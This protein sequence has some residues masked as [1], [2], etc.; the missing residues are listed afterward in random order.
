MLSRYAFNWSPHRDVRGFY[1]LIWFCVKI[2]LEVGEYAGDQGFQLPNPVSIHREYLRLW[3]RVE[4]CMQHFTKMKLL[5]IGCYG[6]TMPNTIQPEE[7][8]DGQWQ[9]RH[10]IRNRNSNGNLYIR[11]LYFNDGV[12][13][14]NYNWLNN[15]WNGNNPAALL[16]TY[17]ISL[18]YWESFVFATGHASHRASCRSHLSLVIGQYISYR[19]KIWFPRVSSEIFLM[20]LL[21]L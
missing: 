10:S 16:A 11:Y 19:P 1:F 7:L 18:P 17:F 21:F 8:F 13:N 20:Y 6:I 12:W 3:F 4:W 2:F 5:G 14:R 15:D 9:G